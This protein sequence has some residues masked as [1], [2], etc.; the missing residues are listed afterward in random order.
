[1][2][3]KDGKALIAPVKVE[4]TDGKALP[5][6]VQVETVWVTNG[7][8]LWSSAAKEVRKGKEEAPALEVVVRDG[9]KWGPSIRVDVV[10]LLKDEKGHSYLLRASERKI[11]RTD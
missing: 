4:S 7:D 10:V 11:H 8:K 5:K 3:E 9:P 6:G 1:L 2:T